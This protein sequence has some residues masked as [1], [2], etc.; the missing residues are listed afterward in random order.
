VLQGAV[1]K[2]RK[3]TY[4]IFATAFRC[5]LRACA[6]FAKSTFVVATYA[7]FI[8]ELGGEFTRKFL[9]PFV[10]GNA[11]P[12]LQSLFSAWTGATR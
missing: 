4:L 3:L 2:S 11:R 12:A 8:R 10:R 6:F 9:R 7:E 5:W 1:Y